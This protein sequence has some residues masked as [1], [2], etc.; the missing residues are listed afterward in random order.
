MLN[1][2]KSSRGEIAM[3][4][5]KGFRKGMGILILQKFLTIYVDISKFRR[6]AKGHFGFCL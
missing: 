3:S 1:E 4:E 6:N 2:G 5:R